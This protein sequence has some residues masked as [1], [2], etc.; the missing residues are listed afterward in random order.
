MQAEPP[1]L[2]SPKPRAGGSAR[3]L[4]I[5]VQGVL[6]GVRACGVP[7]AADISRMASTTVVKGTGG[8][9][10][11]MAVLRCLAKSLD[12]PRSHELLLRSEDVAA[13]LKVGRFR[14]FFSLL[15]C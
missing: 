15:F 4:P 14:A 6:R 12:D 8:L 10:G 2:S 9:A 11:P 3:R 7:T 1:P 5:D 13:S